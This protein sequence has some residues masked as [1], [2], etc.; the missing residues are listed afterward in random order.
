MTQLAL[1]ENR[2]RLLV[3]DD[4]DAVRAM[5]TRHLGGRYRCDEAADAKAALASFHD[6]RHDLVITDISLPDQ[7]GLQLLAE[8]RTLNPEAQVVVC[9]GLQEIEH[10]IEALRRGAV[11]FVSKPFRLEQLD[12]IIERALQQQAQQIAQNH[13]QHHLEELVEERTAQLRQMNLTVNEMFE[14][15]YLSYRATLQSLATALETRQIEPYGHVQRVTAYCLRLG[16]E[17]NLSDSE[18]VALEN[19]ALLHDIG[20]IALPDY[21]L[22]KT[23]SLSQEERELTRRHIDY[24]AQILSS[25]KFLNDAKLVVLQHHERWDGSGYPL[26]LRETEICLNARIFAI[27]DTLDALTSDRTYRPAQPFEVAEEEIRRCSGTQFDPRLV[28]AFFSIPR[29]EWE[30]LR[31][32]ATTGSAALEESR[33]R[34]IRT[35]V[36]IQK[37]GRLDM[38]KTA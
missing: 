13:Q 29:Q 28:E 30:D 17:L 11:D 18:M 2:P 22:N 38:P 5:L 16:R 12:L 19:G 7:N 36:M 4:E 10:A 3:V 8:I 20:M 33:R 1:S 25:I 37:T 32:M 14:E 31:G 24:G 9:S 6:R 34:G 27:A 15:L 21:V 23:W 35:M 26:G